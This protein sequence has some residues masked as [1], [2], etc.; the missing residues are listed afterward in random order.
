VSAA[1][2]EAV[3]GWWSAGINRTLSCREEQAKPSYAARDIRIRSIGRLT[4]NAMHCG[5][6]GFQC[7]DSAAFSDHRVSDD[8]A[9]P[10][11]PILDPANDP[12]ADNSLIAVVSDVVSDDQ[13][14]AQCCSV[15]TV[16]ST[17]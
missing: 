14:I 7:I 5:P 10:E 8:G 3:S 2:S 6:R 13:I 16:E 17:S 15:Q 12:S 1:L 9:S 4:H 11:P